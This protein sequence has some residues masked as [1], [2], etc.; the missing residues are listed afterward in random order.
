[1]RTRPWQARTRLASEHVR[2]PL[3]PGFRRARGS[4]RLAVD[5]GFCHPNPLAR[6][7][8]TKGEP[9]LP[10]ITSGSRVLRVEMLTPGRAEALT[11]GAARRADRKSPTPVARR[12]AG[13]LCGLPSHQAWNPKSAPLRDDDWGFGLPPPVRIQGDAPDHGS[14]TGATRQ[15]EIDQSFYGLEIRRVSDTSRL[16]DTAANHLAGARQR[17]R[18]G[19]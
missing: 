6:K 10:A 13:M 15:V 4:D 1:M 7:E 3:L 9:L 19:D 8:V 14:S 16:S 17:D 5:K 12:S 18:Q 2:A 11:L